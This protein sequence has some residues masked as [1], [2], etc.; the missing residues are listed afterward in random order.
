MRYGEGSE[1]VPHPAEWKEARSMADVLIVARDSVPV[2]AL[3][4]SLERDGYDVTIAA[5]TFAA[6]P[7]LY[8]NPHALVVI[9]V[10]E[11]AVDTTDTGV[12]MLVDADPGWLGRHTFIS[13]RESDLDDFRLPPSIQAAMLEPF[14]S[15][16]ANP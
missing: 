14:W 5:N 1:D 3:R 11:H 7:V 16:S 4:A 2:R 8:E 13:L 10:P 12:R 6:L 9:S 15:E